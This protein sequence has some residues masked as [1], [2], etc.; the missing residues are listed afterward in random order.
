MAQDKK[1]LR[2]LIVDDTPKNVQLLGTF[3]NREGYHIIVA[4]NG[5][6]ALK[7]VEKTIPDLILLDIMMPELDGFE[8][9]KR[10]KAASETKDI[11]IIFLTAKVETEDILKGFELGAVDYITKPLQL[12]EVLARVNTHLQV[13]IAQKEVENKNEQMEVLI[14]QLKVLNNKLSKYLSPQVY[15]TIFSGKKDVKLESYRKELTVFFSDIQGFTNMTDSMEPEELSE[16][17]NHYLNEMAEIAL[18]YGGTIDKF[19]GDAVMVFF[20]DPESKGVQEDALACV[21]MAIDM[22]TRM[23]AL[24]REWSTEGVASPLHIR[25]GINT[26]HCTVGNF[27]SENRLDYTIIGGKVN[28]ASRLETN[29]APDQILISHSTYT[30]IKEKIA[31]EKRGEIQVKGIAHPVQTYQ[32]VDTIKDLEESASQWTNEGRGYSISVDVKQL[33]REDKP[34]LQNILQQAIDYLR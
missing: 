6:Q 10:L 8:T 34:R 2:I 21:Q 22:R 32:I 27:G 15:E 26:G 24:R 30:L 17:L 13:S 19:I 11:P 25:I 23:E 14:D 4:Q 9:C 29:A 20:G 18:K 28:L 7:T 33:S 12:P 1:T 31:C 3:L 16:L 5:I